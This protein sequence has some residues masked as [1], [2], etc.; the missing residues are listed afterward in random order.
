VSI[1][2]APKVKEGRTLYVLIPLLLLHLTLLSLQIEDPAGTLL[3]KKWV[4]RA[5][6]PFLNISSSVSVSVNRIWHDYFWLRGAREENQRLQNTL[7]QLSVQANRLEE[8]RQE[9]IRLRRLVTLNESIPFEAIGARVVGRT[10]NYMSNVV[11]IDRGGTDGITVD[12]PVL[13]GSGIIG[14]TVLVTGHTAQVQLIT[15]ADASV[16][17]MVDRT[18][19]PGVLRGS[20]DPLLDMNYI[21]NTEQ[22]NVGDLVVTSGLDGIF[23]KGLPI[24]KVVDSRKSNS[25]FRAIKVEPSADLVHIEEVSVIIG[26]LKPEKAGEVSDDGK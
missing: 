11:Y 8:I 23:P 6:S 4:L 13:S 20:G 24:G 1:E 7:Q 9:N 15:N 2:L 3:V 10:P 14:R 17:A 26:K 12:A 25:V 5:E 22:I 16:G 19:S 18:R 21:S